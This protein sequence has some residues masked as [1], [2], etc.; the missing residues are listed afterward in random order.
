MN[1]RARR[2]AARRA[3][4]RLSRSRRP[5]PIL[6]RL[7]LVVA[8]VGLIVLAVVVATGGST[9]RQGRVIG[10]LAV[11]GAALIALAWAGRF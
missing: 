6:P 11:A 5:L 10:A 8:G 9:A 7:L 2:R 1:R 4:S 3:P